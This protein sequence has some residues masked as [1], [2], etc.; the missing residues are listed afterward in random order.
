MT[1]GYANAFT[2]YVLVDYDGQPHRGNGWK[3]TGA[4]KAYR[5]HRGARVAAGLLGGIVIPVEVGVP[6]EVL[7]RYI[8][9]LASEC[10]CGRSWTMPECDGECAE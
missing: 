1:G 2:L 4:V 8:R 7:S 10:T 6:Q 9:E 5:T 3:K